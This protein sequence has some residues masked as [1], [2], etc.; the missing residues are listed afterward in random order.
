M[1]I[2]LERGTSF[3]TPANYGDLHYPQKEKTW[4]SGPRIGRPIKIIPRAE[5]RL[6]QE[7]NQNIIEKK[8]QALLSLVKV[9]V[10]DATMR[11]RWAK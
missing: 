2:S 9:S 8:L 6:I 1:S 7:I 3:G 5:Q 11:N 10:Y 4:N